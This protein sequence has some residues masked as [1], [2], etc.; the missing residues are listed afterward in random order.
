MTEVHDN[1]QVAQDQDYL[2]S[3]GGPANG[4][5]PP[6][7]ADGH[8][9]ATATAGSNGDA[10]TATVTDGSDG[11]EIPDGPPVTWRQPSEWVKGKFQDHLIVIV[12]EREKLPDYVDARLWDQESGR[13][14]PESRVTAPKA[15]VFHDPECRQPCFPGTWKKAQADASNGQP[16]AT[17]TG[18]AKDPKPN[19]QLDDP[20]DLARRWLRRYTYATDGWTIAYWDAGWYIWNGMHYAAVDDEWVR[21]DISRYCERYFVNVNIALLRDLDPTKEEKAP[22]VKRVTERLVRDVEAAA[23]SVNG[24]LITSVVAPKGK[25]WRSGVGWPTD[26]V[27]PMKNVLVNIRSLVEDLPGPAF[28]APTPRFFCTYA[29]PYEFRPDLGDPVVGLGWLGSAFPD[30]AESVDSLQEFLGA[31]LDHSRVYAKDWRI[32]LVYGPTRSGKGLIDLLIEQLVGVENAAALTPE[33]A[34]GPFGLEECVG[35]LALIVGDTK[36]D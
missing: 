25:A 22:T 13:V 19:I 26:E 33:A 32:L 23:K 18:T 6:E 30:D 5:L 7:S 9:A 10:A 11:R 31:F 1:A 2:G 28:I 15:E 8:P 27:I 3:V 35:K 14:R 20:H 36:I 21:A 12:G 17:A 16:G 34:S 4:H 29:L 24:V